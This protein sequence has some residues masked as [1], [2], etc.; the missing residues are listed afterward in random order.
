LFQAFNFFSRLLPDN[1]DLNKAKANNFN[2]YVL[3]CDTADKAT[4]Q[5]PDANPGRFH[6][7]IINSFGNQK[8]FGF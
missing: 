1:S 7:A 8:F 3:S 4:A 6:H 2:Q 5:P